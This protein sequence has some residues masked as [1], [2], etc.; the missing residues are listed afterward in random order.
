MVRIRL[1]SQSYTHQIDGNSILVEKLKKEL[2]E[3]FEFPTACIKLIHGGKCLEN[4]HEILS[5]FKDE[6]YMAIIPIECHI[7]CNC[8]NNNEYD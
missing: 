6:I 2:G 7:H 4:N 5:D 3:R 8:C 1:I